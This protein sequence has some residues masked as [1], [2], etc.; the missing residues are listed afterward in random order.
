MRRLARPLGLTLALAFCAPAPAGA[1]QPAQPALD[2]SPGT[3]LNLAKVEEQLG[4]VASASAHFQLALK[5]LPESDDR[6]PVA[7]EGVARLGPR[8]PSL[9]I[10]RAVGAPAAMRIKLDGVAVAVSSVG[11]DQPIDPGTYTVSTTA[12]GHEERRYEV[13]LIE[14]SHLTLAVEPG[15][16]LALG[17]APA[18]PAARF[19]A[20]QMVGLAAGGVGLAGLGIGAATGILAIVKKG[21]AASACPMPSRCTADGIETAAGGKALAG[22]STASFAVG[23]AGIGAGVVLLL[24]GRDKA[25]APPAVVSAAVLPG[26]GG[27]VAVGNF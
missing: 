15:K 7:R 27:V 22:V 3:L 26:G 2:P 9:R 24:V 6:Y 8:V 18:P 10:D 17:G 20:A 5:Q 21:Q 23:V 11:V 19:S 4:K 13:K 14:S 16:E 12:A 1:Q 25:P